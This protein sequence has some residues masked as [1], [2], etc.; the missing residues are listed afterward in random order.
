MTELPKFSFNL[1]EQPC[2]PVLDAMGKPHTLSLRDVFVRAHE[3][4]EIHHCSPVVA[5]GLVR[6]C[7]AILTDVHPIKYPSQWAPL[8]LRGAFDAIA[9]DAYFEKY[10]DRFDL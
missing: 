10:K 7:V 1:A 3:L 2:V 8:W 4:K 9:I 6:L 5:A